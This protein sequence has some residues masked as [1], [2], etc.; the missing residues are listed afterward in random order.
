MERT[1]DEDDEEDGESY[2]ELLQL[3]DVYRLCCS[4]QFSLLHCQDCL[5]LSISK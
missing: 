4:S 2:E 3:K 5:H 1:P